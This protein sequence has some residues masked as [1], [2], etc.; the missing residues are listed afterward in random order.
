[1]KGATLT[2]FKR[3]WISLKYISKQVASLHL[4]SKFFREKN[5]LRWYIPPV[6]AV[7]NRT[8]PE[9]VIFFAPGLFLRSL[10]FIHAT[11]VTKI[12]YAFVPSSYLLYRR[13][14]HVATCRR[15]ISFVPTRY[16]ASRAIR[17]NEHGIPDEKSGCL[18]TRFNFPSQMHQPRIFV[19]CLNVSC[20]DETNEQPRASILSAR[21]IVAR[22]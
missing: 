21:R 20:L 10:C 15:Q 2:R 5:G 14:R 6:L 9:R 18:R 8:L 7:N 17:L 12:K 16:S 1:M 3:F 13:S 4:R 11:H 22:N 19:S